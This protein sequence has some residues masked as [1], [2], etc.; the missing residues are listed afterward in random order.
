M[1]KV[2]LT[3][4]RVA[5]CSRGRRCP[6]WFVRADRVRAFSG[7]T[8]PRLQDLRRD[9]PEWLEQRTISFADG[10][11]GAF[12]RGA[13]LVVSHRWEQAAAPDQQGVQ[14]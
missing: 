12:A 4:A 5:E 8:L 10:C 6:F 11:D 7:V 9:H 13:F 14:F 3:A 1:A 2:G